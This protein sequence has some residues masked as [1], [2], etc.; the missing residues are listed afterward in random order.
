MSLAASA[1]PVIGTTAMMCAS[2]TK[3]GHGTHL[4]TSYLPW[5]GLHVV[6]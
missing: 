1:V 5:S 2:R 3:E 4:V 6:A